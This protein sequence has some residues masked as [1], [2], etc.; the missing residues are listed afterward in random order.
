MKNISKNKSVAMVTGVIIMFAIFITKT[1]TAQDSRSNEK[2]KEKTIILKV[3]TDKDGEKTEID[4]IFTIPE[5]SDFPEGIECMKKIREEMKGLEDEMKEIQ[6]QMFVDEPDST[7]MDSLQKSVRKMVLI[8]KGPKDRIRIHCE[9]SGEPDFDLDVPYKLEQLRKLDEF[10]H[11]GLDRY[12]KDPDKR[13]YRFKNKGETISDIIG[14]I[15]MDRVRNYSV[16]NTKYG[17]KIVIEIE[18]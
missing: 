6:I 11:Q 18:D 8:T 5:G 9:K 10:G 17:K 3:V 15:P 13:I 4:T 1:T 16:K 7:L 2:G 14:E 12:W